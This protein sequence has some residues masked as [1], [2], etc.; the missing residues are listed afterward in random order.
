MHLRAP[1]VDQGVHAFGWSV[2]FFLYMWLGALAIKIPGG[3]AFVVS[4]VA[5]GAIFLFVRLRGGDRPEIGGVSAGRVGS[6]VA[7]RRDEAIREVAAEH[8]LEPIE[9]GSL[10]E[11]SRPP[12]ACTSARRRSERPG[13]TSMRRAALMCR[14]SVRGPAPSIPGGREERTPAFS[15]L[16]IE[17][18]LVE[19]RGVRARLGTRRPPAARLAQRRAIPLRRSRRSGTGRRRARCE[20]T[21][22]ETQ[23]HT[24]HSTATPKSPAAR[25]DQ[26]ERRRRHWSRPRPR[27]SSRSSTATPPLGS[28][29]AAAIH[30]LGGDEIVARGHEVPEREIGSRSEMRPVEVGRA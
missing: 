13:A 30:E 18:P 15:E 4:A 10:H 3:V 16:E 19:A 25:R 20:T 17:S 7:E 21:L 5:A 2:V 12:N 8:S 1:S 14:R 11:G 29:V 23:A 27:G 22:T 24:G 6:P 28:C 9:R 26:R